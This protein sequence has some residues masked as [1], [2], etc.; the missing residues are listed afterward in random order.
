[1]GFYINKL[2]F[3]IIPIF[4]L[5]EDILNTYFKRK[6]HHHHESR[7]RY[8]FFL[9]KGLKMHIVIN[10]GKFILSLGN[11]TTAF[12]FVIAIQKVVNSQNPRTLGLRG[13]S[14]GILAQ[15]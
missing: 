8:R 6:R 1:M 3:F 9:K 5:Y 13:L 15:Y 2:R 7:G 10:N 11:F 14:S 12:R 4:L